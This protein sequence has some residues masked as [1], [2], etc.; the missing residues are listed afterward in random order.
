MSINDLSQWLAEARETPEYQFESVAFDLAEELCKIMEAKGISKAD[1]ARDMGKSRAW[2]TKLLRGDHNM[3]LKTVVDVYWRLGYKLKIESELAIK[4]AGW[5]ES[6]TAYES[7]STI[8]VN[9]SRK[10]LGDAAHFA[11]EPM[12]QLSEDANV[13]SVAA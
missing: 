5:T 2:A 12:E 7:K 3:T 10:P 8:T 11:D 13:K 6:G 1:L 9:S 4:N